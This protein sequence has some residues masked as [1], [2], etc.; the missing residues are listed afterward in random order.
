MSTLQETLHR[1]QPV[2]AAGGGSG[3]GSGP[4]GRGGGGEGP[5]R[6]SMIPRRSY[7]TALWLVQASVA[8]FFAAFASAYVVRRGIAT[9]WRA[10]EMPGLLWINTLVLLG[11]SGAIEWARRGLK[12]EGPAVFKRWWTL[13]TVLGIAF[14][15]GQAIVWSQLVARGINMTSNPSHSFFYLLTV[16]HAGHLLIG[17]GALGYVEIR[18]LRGRLAGPQCLA[19]DLSALYWHFLSGLW[20]VLL[21]LMLVWR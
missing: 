11:G 2:P 20:L 5:P 17:V 6:S 7:F 8:M 13:A 1:A 16:L 15:A 10:M 21:A 4:S 19:A 9:D 12:G 14:L 3:S 18:V